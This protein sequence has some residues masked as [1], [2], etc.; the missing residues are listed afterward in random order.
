MREFK[1]GRKKLPGGFKRAWSELFVM[2]GCKNEFLNQVL[3]IK[4]ELEKQF[5]LS[6]NQSVKS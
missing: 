4:E 6:K 1:S 5:K 3:P 2:E